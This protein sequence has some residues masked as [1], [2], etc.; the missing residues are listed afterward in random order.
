MAT[1]GKDGGTV[2]L[3]CA[4]GMN[5]RTAIYASPNWRGGLTRIRQLIAKHGVIIPAHHQV[6]FASIPLDA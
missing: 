6:L 3:E 5:R 2:W 1:Y 4:H